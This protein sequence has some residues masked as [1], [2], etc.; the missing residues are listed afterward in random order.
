M[1]WVDKVCVCVCVEPVCNQQ[2]IPLP[3]S[4][5]PPSPSAVPAAWPGQVRPPPGHC[6]Q[7]EEA[8][9]CRKLTLQP[10]C[11]NQT[12]GWQGGV[13]CMPTDAP[14]DPSFLTTQVAS[15]D[16]PHCLFYG[17][18]GAGKK[19]LIMALLREVYGPGAE[20][21]GFRYR[22]VVRCMW[23]WHPV[24]AWAASLPCLHFTHLPCAPAIGDADQG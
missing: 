8:G 6:C 16:F 23:L 21:V 13:L 12:A 18:P 11:I 15:G 24:C 10:P 1:L 20:K 9:E 7:F 2:D 17:P 14:G 5:K 22:S 3:P 4:L 19:T